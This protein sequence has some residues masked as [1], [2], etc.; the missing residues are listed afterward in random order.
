MRR[1]SF[2]RV[3]FRTFQK[4]KIILAKIDATSIDTLRQRVSTNIGI[5][6]EFDSAR[7]G[8]IT[9]VKEER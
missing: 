3:S 7:I 8:D 2:I 9:Y 5:A 6:E 4:V 1:E